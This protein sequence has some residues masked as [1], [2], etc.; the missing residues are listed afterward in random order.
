MSRKLDYYFNS[1]MKEHA[2]S[3]EEVAKVILKAMTSEDPKL[4]H[5]ADD[6]A[7]AALA[8]P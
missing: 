2:S 4:S 8:A 1:A 7:A 3:S 5:T 6:D